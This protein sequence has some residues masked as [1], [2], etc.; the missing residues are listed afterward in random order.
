MNMLQLKKIKA[1]KYVTTDGKFEISK[2][3]GYWFAVDTKTG[4]SVVDSERTLWEI[5]SSL[6]GYLKKHSQI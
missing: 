1:G 3:F 6:Q 4:Q 2:D 5:K